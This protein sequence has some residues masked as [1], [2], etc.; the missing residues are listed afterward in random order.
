MKVK[1]LQLISYRNYEKLNIELSDTLNIFLGKNAQGKTNIVESIYYAAVGHSYRTSSES[2]LIM[3]GAQGGSV[4]LSFERRS[5]ENIL[6]FAFSREKRRKI[7]LNGQSIKMRELIG[8]V[9]AVLFSPEDLMIIKGAPA[10]RRRFLDIEL[11]QASPAYYHE[12]SKYNRLILQRNQ[13]LKRIR[14]RSANRDMLSVWDV[15]MAESAAFIVKKRLEAVKKLNMLANLMQRR[16]SGNEENL[17][18]SY[19]I[20]GSEGSEKVTEDLV[21]WY[22]KRLANSIDDDIWRGSTSVGPHRDDLS[23]SVNGI[24]LKSFGS[25]GQQRTAVLSLK[26]SELEFIRSE[27]GE[28]PVLL[29]DDVMSELD[30]KRRTQLVDFIL[31]ERIQTIITATDEAYF[32]EEEMGHLKTSGSYFHVNAGHVAMG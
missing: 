25:Q 31:K 29:L 8:A 20:S 6:E 10:G 16:I 19:E 15:Q 27:N 24:N 18:V 32:P 13:L 30:V 11:S 26:L 14:E 21:S 1:A 12:L 22:N 9:N 5:V 3:L 23:F 2:D 4:K 28:Y 17:T 7:L